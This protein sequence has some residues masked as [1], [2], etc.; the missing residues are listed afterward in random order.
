MN[1]RPIDYESIALPL[2]HTS[3][4][5]VDKSKINGIIS[6]TG[7]IISPFRYFVNM[8]F[9]KSNNFF[10]EN[11]PKLTDISYVKKLME[12]NGLTFL[13]KYGQNF[14][15]N[16]SVPQRTAEMCCE[17]RS[18]GVIEIGPGIGTL[19]EQLAMRFS[20]VVAIEIDSRLIP[21]LDTT[22][23]EYD[24]V[25]VINSDVM[26]IDINSF[27]ETHFKDMDV[28]VCANLPYYIT[29]P[30]IMKLLESSS[31]LKSIT[32]L[33][34]KEVADRLCAP[35]GSPEYGSITASVSYYAE[36]KKLFGVS[37]GSFMPAPKVDSTVIKLSLYDEKPVRPINEKLMFNVIKA[38]FL[39]RRK[40][41]SNAVSHSDIGVSKDVI[42]D[43]LE[44]MN[45][46]RDIRG[47]KLSIKDFALFSDLLYKHMTRASDN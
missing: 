5:T 9:K 18:C 25:T 1:P 2:R 22:L 37:A 14:L 12:E 13:K 27:I 10:G 6:S 8:I 11:M 36:V 38:A 42:G 21:V 20:K 17:D 35:A 30:I 44:E 3:K 28:C 40:T 33:I 24:N 26:D 4:L 46:S 19:T 31:R 39:Q 7:L 15:I 32:L 23:A 45:L 34:Q 43:I 29:T 47:E 16:E 41:L